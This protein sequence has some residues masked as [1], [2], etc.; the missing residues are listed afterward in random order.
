[1]IFQLEL[2][3]SHC[4]QV[5][6]LGWELLAGVETLDQVSEV[7]GTHDGDALGQTPHHLVGQTDPVHH[8][9]GGA[10][11]HLTL[12]LQPGVE[13]LHHLHLALLLRLRP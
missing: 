4:R 13:L 5:G 6:G 11:R 12:Q 3:L 2:S 10:L 9:V 8:Q 7:L 1:M